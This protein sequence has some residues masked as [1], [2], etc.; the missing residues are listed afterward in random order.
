MF[1]L[2]KEKYPTI[3]NFFDT[4][5]LNNDFVVPNSIILHGPD[6]L[7]QYY[8]A[9]LLA[10]GA[11]C[12]GDKS[13]TCECQNCRWIKANEHPEI[14]TISKINSKPD[15]DDSKSVISAKQID[16]IKD[17]LVVSS[18]YHRFFII[19]DADIRELTPE[20][21]EIQSRFDFLNMKLPQTEKGTW[22]PSGLTT[23]C[24]TDIAANALLK[25]IE[26]P[27]A[28]VTFV[29]LTEN[30]ENIISTIVSRSQAFYVAGSGKQ[31]YDF[32]F[33]REPLSNY[34]NIDRRKAIMISDFLIDYSKNNDKPLAYI[35]AAIQAYFVELA[36][37]NAQNT[38]F[39]TRVFDDIEKLQ[40]LITM[41]SSSVREQVVADE[42]GYILTN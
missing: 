12:T 4:L 15:G 10:R 28:N 26:E 19:C 37:T 17:K 14:M 41:L 40:N 3:S 31:I 34:P 39:K 32:E 27:P 23:K 9:L 22:I 18:D 1:E 8:V 35:L 38:A 11:N 6:V 24:F 25:S 5:I 29:F 30:V 16:M 7:C 33:L 36:K 20:E 2:L 42:A 21:R 13:I